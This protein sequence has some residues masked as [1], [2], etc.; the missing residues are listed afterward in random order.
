VFDGPAALAAIEAQ[1]FDLIILDIMLPEM[2]E[3]EVLRRSRDG[4]IPTIFLTA[5]SGLSDRVA[6]LSM[7]ADD[8]RPMNSSSGRSWRR[9]TRWRSRSRRADG[10][11][12]PCCGNW[13]NKRQRGVK[14]DGSRFGF[15]SARAA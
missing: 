3:L 1:P 12:Y 7:G 2:D 6:G 11:S 14:G 9:S 5:R 4:D 8:W 10:N 13:K 15:P